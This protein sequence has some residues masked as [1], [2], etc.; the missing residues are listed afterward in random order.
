LICLSG[1]RYEDRTVSG[2]V[3]GGRWLD[4]DD[5]AP[6]VWERVKRTLQSG[7]VEDAPVGV[8]QPDGDDGPTNYY[9]RL[10]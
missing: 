1:R 9:Y 6:E 8:E 2:V 10:L 7:E 3:L 5:L 4:A